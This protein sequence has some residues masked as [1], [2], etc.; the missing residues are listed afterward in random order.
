VR[1]RV[2][3][4]VL[5]RFEISALTANLDW[6][7]ALELAEEHCVQG[8]VT[9]RLKEAGHAGMPEPAWEKLQG[10]MRTQ[11]LFTLS[12][13]AELFRILNAFAKAGIETILVKGPIVSFSG[14]WRSRGAGLCGSRFTGA[15]RGDS[16]CFQEF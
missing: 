9:E 5:P 2:S 11:H 16:S 13:T 3:F 14:L 12:M 4:A 1:L 8:V 15:R 7:L 10:K 6:N